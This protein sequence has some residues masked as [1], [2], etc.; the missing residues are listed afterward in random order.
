MIRKGQY[1]DAKPR[2]AHPA[3]GLGNLLMSTMHPIKK[4][5]RQNERPIILAKELV[6]D[7]HTKTLRGAKSAPCAS[8]TPTSVRE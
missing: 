1:P 2:F 7:V 4:P 5:N 3:S 8:P 6:M